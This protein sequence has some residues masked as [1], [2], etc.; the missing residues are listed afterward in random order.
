[1]T[2]DPIG[3]GS[4]VVDLRVVDATG[5]IWLEQQIEGERLTLDTRN[6][7]RGVYFVSLAKDNIQ[8]QRKLLKI[9]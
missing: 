3:L 9:Q 6:W 7:P 4:D 5:R 8:L 1:M 2:R